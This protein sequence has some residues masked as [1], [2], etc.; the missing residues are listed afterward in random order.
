M[1]APIPLPLTPDPG[2]AVMR[3]PRWRAELELGFVV[4][5][6]ATIPSHRR[7]LGPL[8]IQKGFTPEGDELWHQIVVHPPGGIASGDDLCVSIDAAQGA[9]VLLTSPG[10]A[11][12]YRSAADDAVATQEI[13]I[14]VAAGASVEWLPLESIVHLGAR[15]RW[16]A[17]VDVHPDAAAVWAEVVCL[18]RPAN[19]ERFTQGALRWTLEFNRSQRPLFIER[20]AIDGVRDDHRRAPA[21]GRAPCFGT[22]VAIPPAAACEHL[23]AVCDAIA[24]MLDDQAGSTCRPNAPGTTHPTQVTAVTALPQALVVRW[25]GA[26]AEDGWRALRAAWALAR[27]AVIGRAAHPPR[28]W[29]Q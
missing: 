21:L 1:N 18:G 27:P 20:G 24:T 23:P 25:A 3:H 10:A 9:R 13:A 2:A 15:A 28:I 26:A 5:D 14:N 11:K 7:H 6:G 22:L 12:W 19:D 16:H 8:R 17:R 4:R 29:T